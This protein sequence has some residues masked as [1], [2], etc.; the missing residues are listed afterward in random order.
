M[1]DFPANPPTPLFVHTWTQWSS[2]LDLYKIHGTLTITASA[3]WPVASTAFYMPIWLPWH[4]PVARVF[5]INGSSVTSV[6]VDFGIYNDDGVLIY[7]TTSTARAGASVVQY[8]TPSAPFILPPGRYYFAHSCDSI[9]T[10]RG[11]MATS[12]GTVARYALAGLLQEA[13][14]LPL[15]ATMT[16]VTVAN[17][18]FPLC[19]ITRTASGF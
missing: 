6:N 1:A 3:T 16:P 13:S 10:N 17:V 2:A 14:A 15:P 8:V 7:N 18:F 19:G 12:T 4:Y 5:W 11:G 9:T